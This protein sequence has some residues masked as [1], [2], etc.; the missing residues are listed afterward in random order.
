MI[1][2]V[3]LTD[4]YLTA[5]EV[6]DLDAL[7]ALYSD[8]VALDEWGENQFIGKD[9]VLNTNKGLFEKFAT[10]YVRLEN[11]GCCGSI[12]MNQLV[13]TLENETE[14]LKVRV[15]DFIDF[16]ESTGLIKSIVV[17]RGF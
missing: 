1:D 14:C 11:Q 2:V 6:R 15:V 17:Y 13:V 4:K 8:N 16:D 5:F 7:S 9:S 12:T 3:K 10:I